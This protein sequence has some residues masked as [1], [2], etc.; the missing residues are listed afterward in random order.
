MLE[1]AEIGHRVAKDVYARE[2]PRLRESL[3]LAQFGQLLGG[4]VA[5]IGMAARQQFM[6]H[7]GV[8]IGAGELVNHIAVP[9]EIE[10][11]HAIQDGIYRRLG[12]AR[13]IGVLDAEQEFAAMVPGEQPV[14]QRR[15][16]PADMQISSRGWRETRDDGLI[17]GAC[18]H[19]RFLQDWRNGQRRRGAP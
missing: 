16:R 1:S 12:G 10:P 7:R 19:A 15:A 8:A 14:E 11:A 4:G 6:R 2:E 18:V 9:A 17:F 5:A 3:L 13:T